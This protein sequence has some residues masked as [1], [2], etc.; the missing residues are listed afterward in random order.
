MDEDGAIRKVSR[1]ATSYR[2]GI[3]C[4]AELWNQVADCL[5]LS[6]VQCVLSRLP[7]DLQRVLREAYV[8]RPWSLPSE[9]GDAEVR[10][11][12]E[13]WC[14]GTPPKPTDT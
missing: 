12:I 8:E 4:P 1:S 3:F 13:R 14:R 6:A 2:N 5:E 10:A 7:A 11:E 9:V